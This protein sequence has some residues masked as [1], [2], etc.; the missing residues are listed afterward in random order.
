MISILVARRLVVRFRGVATVGV[1]PRRK[2]SNEKPGID[3][4]EGVSSCAVAGVTPSKVIGSTQ[5][6]KTRFMV[7]LLEEAR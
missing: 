3:V 1:A 6:A 5:K 4:A 2:L 7:T